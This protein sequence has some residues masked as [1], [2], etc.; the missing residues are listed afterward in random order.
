LV[1]QDTL[2][3]T[4]ELQKNHRVNQSPRESLKN[5]QKCSFP[6]FEKAYRKIRLIPSPILPLNLRFYF[7]LQ[8]NPIYINQIIFKFERTVKSFMM[9]SG[10]S[11][12]NMDEFSRRFESVM[13]FNVKGVVFIVVPMIYLS[14]K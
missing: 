5:H 13:T 3:T 11:S 12:S 10:I 9:S 6:I 4:R 1:H 2:K 7:W 14:I 8:L